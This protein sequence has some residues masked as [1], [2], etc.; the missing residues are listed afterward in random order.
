VPDFNCYLAYVLCTP[1]PG[2]DSP[3]RAIAGYL[4]VNNLRSRFP[5]FPQPVVDYLKVVLFG[6][7]QDADAEVRRSASTA[8]SWFLKALVPEKYPEGLQR[9]MGLLEAPSSDIQE[10]R[11]IFLRSARSSFRAQTALSTFAKLCQDVP[12]ALDRAQLDN[13]PFLDFLVPALLQRME[14]PDTK[15]R[16]NALT[17]LVPFIEPE[18]KLSGQNALGRHIDLFIASLFK[19]A[20]DPSSSVRKQVCTAMVALL[21]SRPVKLV[22]EINGVVDYVLHCTQDD[23][24]E[25]ALE[26]CEFWLTFAE[27]G[28]LLETLRAFLPRVAPVLLDCTIYEDEELFSLGA[29]DDDDATVPDRP[30]DIKPQF[31]S[32][33]VHAQSASTPGQPEASTS[34]ARDA[35]PEPE[36]AEEDEDDLLDED[37]DDF[38]EWTLRKCAAAALDV[39]ATAYE[40]ELLMILLPHLKDKLQ[41]EDWLQRESG[42][43]TLGAM[44][45][46]CIGHLSDHLPQLMP[47]FLQSLGDSKVR[48]L[49]DL[50]RMADMSLC[51]QPLVRSIACWSIGRYSTWLVPEDATPEHKQAFFVPALEGVSAAL[52]R[53]K[54]SDRATW[55]LLRMLLDN[56]K[57]VQEAGC[58]AFATLEEEA[59]AELEP[60]LAP[61][62]QTLVFAFSKYQQKNL[63]ILYDAIGTLA[64]A[65]GETLNQKEYIDLLMPPLIGKWQKLQDDDDDLV[66]LLEV[67]VLLQRQRKLTPQQCMSSVVIA[68][69]AGFL[70]F[71]QPVF[72]RCA[73]IIHTSLVHYQTWQANQSAYEVPDKTFLIVALDLLSGL[74]QGLGAAITP[75]Y[76]GVSNQ[77]FQLLLFCLQFPDAPVRQSAYA[78][79]GD[80]AISVF[81]LLKPYIPQ[82][83][84]ILATQIEHE[85]KA[86]TI[87]A[88]NNAVWAAGE[89]GLKLGQFGSGASFH[90]DVDIRLRDDAVHQPAHGAAGAC[91]PFA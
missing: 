3:S 28:E 81:D 82:I 31:Y 87:S 6:A 49:L 91:P 18:E 13:R 90:A 70:P 53:R 74:T 35:A 62:L 34:K 1:L 68:V 38:S 7:L 43:L 32:G 73:R 16:S 54:P 46:G 23:D 30:E 15:I 69:S 11:A 75:L 78:L 83:M 20:S 41:S 27:D 86:E 9:L 24:K 2:V 61:I 64:D 50:P 12:K 36:E 40:G 88:C 77:I 63:L 21:S 56:N 17:C 58:S 89:L 65:V 48:N 19:R 76:E 44:A 29:L 57:K 42:I 45:E 8:V 4:L 51:V 80:C 85:P 72:E 52:V 39:M 84:P 55:Q 71:A 25:L 59:G 66:P 79:L 22:P 60:F 14:S 33:K 10:V 26:A 5:S 37:D 47:Y 67:G